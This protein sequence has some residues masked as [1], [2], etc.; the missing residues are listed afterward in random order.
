MRNTRWYPVNDARDN[1]GILGNDARDGATALCPR[2]CLCNAHARIHFDGLSLTFMMICRLG[3]I[4]LT[5]R[6][7]AFRFS[8]SSWR[9]AYP[10]A[11]H[12]C[13]RCHHNSLS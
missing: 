6:K 7:S 1:A 12:S 8:G 3:T 10:A 9:P 4:M 13:C 2:K 11:R 5:P